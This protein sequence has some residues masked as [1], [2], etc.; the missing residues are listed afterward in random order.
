MNTQS[1]INVFDSVLAGLELNDSLREQ[2]T[3]VKQA[4]VTFSAETEKERAVVDVVTVRKLPNITTGE[5]HRFIVNRPFKQARLKLASV[6][7]DG[8]NLSLYVVGYWEVP[9]SVAEDVA[10]DII[11]ARLT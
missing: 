10:F 3:A 8:A 11:D 6:Q 4:F 7:S 9:E 1:L 2:L 5:N